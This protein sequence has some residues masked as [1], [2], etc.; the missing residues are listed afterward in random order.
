MIGRV[1]STST[2]RLILQAQRRTMAG[3]GD[4]YNIAGRQFSTEQVVV[5]IMAF[6]GGLVFLGTRGGGKKAP[7]TETA[8]APASTSTEVL[9]I[10]D[11]NFESWVKIP[12]N[13]AKWEKSL[14]G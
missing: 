1:A 4:V 14:E 10:F 5:G 8:A 11:D 6:Y 12:G 2:G 13:M 7:A 9:S 3:G